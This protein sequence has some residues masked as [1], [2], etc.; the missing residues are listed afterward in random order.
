VGQEVKTLIS[1]ADF[2]KGSHQ[3]IWDG[4]NNAGSR[5]ASGNY[6]ARLTFGNFSKS[7]KMT[8]LK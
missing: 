2:K 8:M 4:T 6:I 3:V 5:V 7:I 1:A